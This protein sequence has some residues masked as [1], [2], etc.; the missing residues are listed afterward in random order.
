MNNMDITTIKN[1]FNKGERDFYDFLYQWLSDYSDYYIPNSSLFYGLDY[2]KYEDEF[3]S[4]FEIEL[5]DLE[6]HFYNF[7]F[8]YYLNECKYEAVNGAI[9][10]Y[11]VDRFTDEFD[12]WENIV[13]DRIISYWQDSG[14]MFYLYENQREILVNE[15]VRSVF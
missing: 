3:D 13:F 6:F 4:N 1:E 11:I 10:T 2:T 12:F 9:E 15:M 14:Y 8:E 7:V 5:E